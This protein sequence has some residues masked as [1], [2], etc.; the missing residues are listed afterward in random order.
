KSRSFSIRSATLGSTAVS[1]TASTCVLLVSIPTA[2]P[3]GLSSPTRPIHPLLV[4]APSHARQQPPD[5]PQNRR[6]EP[7]PPK[8]SPHHNCP[9]PVHRLT[10]PHK[11]RPVRRWQRP[12][13]P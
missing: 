1:P 9:A 10:H 13:L 8:Q 2:P 7:A 5:T 12:N 11:P 4:R 3:P 6:W